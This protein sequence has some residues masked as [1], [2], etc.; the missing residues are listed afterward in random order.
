MST[1]I[2]TLAGVSLA[3]LLAGCQTVGPNYTSPTPPAVTSFA[4]AGDAA[5]MLDTAARP[6]GAWWTALG[7]PQ[8]NDVMSQALKDSPTLAEANATLQR[9]RSQLAQVDAT[10]L[11]QVDGNASITRERININQFG[12]S[13][14]GFTSPTISLYSIGASVSYDLDLFGGARRGREEAQAMLEEQSRRAD[15]AY[16]TL[17]GKVAL[18]AVRIAAIRAQ[19]DA[20]RAVIAD[21][22]RTVDLARK[23]EQAGGAAP[24]SV[25]PSVAQLAADRAA[26]PP[27]EAQ[28][29]QARHALALL[30]GQAPGNW[31]A[32]DF[33]L[34]AFKAPTQIPVGVPSEMVRR[35]PDILAAEAALHAAT[36]DI[37]VQTAKLYPD[38]KLN[39]GYQQGALDGRD[40]FKYDSS[41][42]NF[43]PAVSLPLFDG[44]RRKAGVSAAEAEAKAADARYRQ[45]VLT[46]FNQVADALDALGRDDALIKARTEQ[47]DSAQRSF[48]DAQRAYDLGG[49]T[50]L[51][52]VD[53]QRTLSRARRD[54]VASQG[55]RYTHIVDL[56]TATAADWRQA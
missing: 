37:G 46:A 24:A 7:S 15:A 1:P 54:L 28:L 53:A 44:G 49:G 8:L 19:L 14:P 29:A 31:T 10:L 9:S 4:M 11:P 56:F 47:V 22:E 27:L 51:A 50:L 41:G 35:R 16:L 3:A 12:F 25:T 5:P 55:D 43:G 13:L 20:A 2:R 40:L 48:A 38:I 52:V 23:A 34:A 26:I 6:A 36:A 30:V 45:T 32:P 39:A 42:W 33:D 18:Q 21:G 17:T